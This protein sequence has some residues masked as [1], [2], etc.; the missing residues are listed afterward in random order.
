MLHMGD[1]GRYQFW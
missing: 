1:R